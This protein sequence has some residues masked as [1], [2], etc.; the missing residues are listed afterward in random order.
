MAATAGVGG[1]VA[2]AATAVAATA[3]VAAAAGAGA[4]V[5]ATVETGRLVPPVLVRGLLQLHLVV[6]AP[7]V[8]ELRPFPS[9]PGGRM[10]ARRW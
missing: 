10:G 6:R 5:A 7:P 3:V 4:A 2:D 1:A 9:R 8:R